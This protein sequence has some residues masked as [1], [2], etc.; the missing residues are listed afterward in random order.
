[1]V[2]ITEIYGEFP[3]GKTQLCHT[4]CVSCHVGVDHTKFFLEPIATVDYLK[5]PLEMA[6][7]EWM[8]TLSRMD[9][10]F[11]RALPTPTS[12]PT[13]ITLNSN[14]AVLRRTLGGSVS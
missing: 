10:R 1:M 3:S 9:R 5:E 2:S 13:F 6:G 14:G 12:F 7:A 8:K 4:L 11:H